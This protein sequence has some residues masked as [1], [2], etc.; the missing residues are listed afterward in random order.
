MMNEYCIANARRFV[1]GSLILLLASA[2]F[3]L[4]PKSAFQ[5]RQRSKRGNDTVTVTG[6][7]KS[8]GSSGSCD[9]HR[10]KWI[11]DSAGPLYTNSTCPAIRQHQNCRGNGRPD[12]GYEN[13]RWKPDD[14]ELPRFDARKFL[15][16]MRGKTLAF[17]G[18][19]VA[20]NQ[21]QSLVCILWQVCHLYILLVV[22]FRQ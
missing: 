10:G 13:W 12:T 5:W 11:P 20:R 2:S 3:Q 14:C 15:E 9:L 1:V 6:G 22:V 16:L 7:D 19:S 8:S 4:L 21:M 18:D 17:V